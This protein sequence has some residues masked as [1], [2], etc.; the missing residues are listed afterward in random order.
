MVFVAGGMLASD[1][2]LGWLDSS[3]ESATVRWIAEAT[4]TVVLFSDASRIDLAGAAP[5]VRRAAC[6]CSA[7]GLPLT[8]VGGAARGRR[9][10]RRAAARSRP[11]CSRSCSPRPTRRSGR[12]SSPTRASPR[13]SARGSTSRAA[14]TTGSASR[15]SLIAIAVAE[16]DAR[17]R[18]ATAPRCGSCSRR[19]ATAASAASSRGSQPRPC[20]SAS[21]SRAAWSIDL[22]PD[23]PRRRGRARLRAG[24]VDR[25]QRLHRRLRRRAPSSAACVAR[26]AAR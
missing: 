13:A 16:A 14:S 5:R 1:D 4:L 26:S 17:A 22:A 15:C 7:I 11:S 18:S 24:R 12:R 2:V 23:H 19:S 25:R 20:V 10:A 6:G 9:R 3:I 21:A 8:I